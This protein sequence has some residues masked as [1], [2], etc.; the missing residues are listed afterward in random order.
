MYR[1]RRRRRLGG[2]INYDRYLEIDIAVTNI[3]RSALKRSAYKISKLV[4]PSL[5][6][7]LINDDDYLGLTDPEGINDSRQIVDATKSL[8]N[9]IS[10]YA[11][12]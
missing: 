6:H 10:K 1:I 9:L 4:N 3:M 12:K 5:K 7:E 11:T 2:A 8:D